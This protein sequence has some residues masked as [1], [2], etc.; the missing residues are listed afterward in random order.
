MKLQILDQKETL[1]AFA[2]SHDSCHYQKTSQW[3][4]FM[5][6][7]QKCTPQYIGFFD[8]EKLA[9]TACLL[10]CKWL[11]HTYFYVPSGS[12]MESSDADTAAEAMQLLA[13]YAKA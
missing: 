11:S 10:K 7:Q 1:D 8:E 13:D 6:K 5:Q 4:A 9:G 2:I 12:C 3:A